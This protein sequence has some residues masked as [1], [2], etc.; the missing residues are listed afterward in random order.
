VFVRAQMPSLSRTAYLLT[1]STASAQDLVQ[2][3]LLRLYQRRDWVLAADVPLA[4]A[5]RALANQFVND[6]RKPA[7]R[8]IILADVPERH[9]A[10]DGSH[11]VVERD[12]MW[13]LLATLP[14]RQRAA[15]VL[16]FYD[17]LPD[18]EIAE[19]LGARIGTVRSLISRALSALRESP[20]MESIGGGRR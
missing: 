5:R 15:L 20:E 14:D 6:R 2:D 13:R 17:D 19:A 18:A 16:R 11:A 9:A 10:P 1:G 3:T 8:E 12:A 7:R 4:Y